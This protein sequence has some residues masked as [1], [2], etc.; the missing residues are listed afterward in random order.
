MKTFDFA[1]ELRSWLMAYASGD[2]GVFWCERA[3]GCSRVQFGSGWVAF[4]IVSGAKRLL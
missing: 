4:D 3:F 1:D 2:C